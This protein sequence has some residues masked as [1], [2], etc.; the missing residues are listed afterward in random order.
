ME[1]GSA[2]KSTT[3]ETLGSVGEDGLG[4][5]ERDRAFFPPASSRS[6]SRSLPGILAQGHGQLPPRMRVALMASGEGLPPSGSRPGRCPRPVQVLRKGPG[7][8]RCKRQLGAE[9][10]WT[11]VAPFR[12]ARFPARS[13]VTGSP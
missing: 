7:V 2:S 10:R 3:G 12:I 13:A 5:K 6:P 11:R 9:T 1:P 8:T 4:G